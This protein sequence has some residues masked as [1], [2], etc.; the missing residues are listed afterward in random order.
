[1]DEYKIK[2]YEVLCKI[3]LF[4]GTILSIYGLFQL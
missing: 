4:L 1:M 2:K 3:I